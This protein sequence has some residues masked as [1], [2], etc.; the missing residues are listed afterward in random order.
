M[1]QAI[2]QTVQQLDANVPLFALRTVDEQLR[3]SVTNERLVAGLSILFGSLATLLAMIG[4]Y[5]VMAYS[6]ARRTREIGIRMALGAQ[7]A[8]VAWLV[9]AK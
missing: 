6:V 4:L 8:R 5:G 3:M 9:D 2:R 7:P 1:T